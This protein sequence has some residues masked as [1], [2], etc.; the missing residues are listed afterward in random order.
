M[1]QTDKQIK[2][3]ENKKRDGLKRINS[4][5]YYVLVINKYLH[6]LGLGKVWKR[7]VI[8]N[9]IKQFFI[10]V[11]YIWQHYIYLH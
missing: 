1:R 8:N 4:I 6:K 10:V 9:K 5:R 7:P 11:V 2:F 3:S